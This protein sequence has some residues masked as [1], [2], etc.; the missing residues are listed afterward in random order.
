MLGLA[1]QDGIS[2]AGSYQLNRS[3]RIVVAGN[4][5]VDDVGVAVGVD[6]GQ[7]GD[8]H[9]AGLVDRVLLLLGIE[10]HEALRQP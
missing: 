4:R 2:K 7:G 10:E 5:Q 6:Q 8:P 9:L 3:D 1:F